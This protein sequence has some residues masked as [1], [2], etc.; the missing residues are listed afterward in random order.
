MFTF[1][2]GP[3]HKTPGSSTRNE[4]YLKSVLSS[5]YQHK[6]NSP[7]PATPCSSS[8][9]TPIRSAR[10]S[11]SSQL[12]S[13]PQGTKPPIP[14]H[15]TPK[16]KIVNPFDHGILDAL[17]GP[18]FMSPGVFSIASTPSTDEKVIMICEIYSS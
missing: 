12:C 8:F 10:N 17:H 6:T 7:L 11:P 4:L 5:P 14:V 3:A 15:A 9:Q 18:M 1:S 16:Q 2:P 13:T